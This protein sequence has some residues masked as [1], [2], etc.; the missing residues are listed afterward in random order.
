MSNKA[1]F[2]VFPSYLLVLAMLCLVGHQLVD[3]FGASCQ[4]SQTAVCGKE[5]KD[6]YATDVNEN[7][8]NDHILHSG[9]ELPQVA[10]PIVFS[11]FC[12]FCAIHYIFLAEV[13]P[14]VLSPPPQKFVQAFTYYRC[15]K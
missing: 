12:L 11:F 13:K 1:G 9:F 10:I 7:S 3:A 15:K 6:S 4:P 5:I 14:P 2:P 8:W